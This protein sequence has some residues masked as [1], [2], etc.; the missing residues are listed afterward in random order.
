M[1][2][3]GRRSNCAYGKLR[4]TKLVVAFTLLEGTDDTMV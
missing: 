3:V 1:P 2:A 4:H